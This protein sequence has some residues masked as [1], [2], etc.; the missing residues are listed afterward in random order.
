M[1]TRCET[2]LEQLAG[3]GT[4]WLEGPPG[5]GKSALASALLHA[6]S[7]RQIWLR[8]RGAHRDLERLEQDLQVAMP[9][10]S[11]GPTP[12]APRPYAD[13]PPGQCIAGMLERL[14]PC[15]LVLDGAEAVADSK[16]F[17]TWLAELATL[18]GVDNAILVT[19]RVPPP[20]SLARLRLEARMG[21]MA[22]RDLCLSATEAQALA[23][24]TVPE[25]ASEPE[26]VRQA[27]T[28]SKGWVAGFLA[29]LRRAAGED[30][31]LFD[32]YLEHEV[33][34]DLPPQVRDLLTSMA[35]LEHTPLAVARALADPAEQ[36]RLD[37]LARGNRLLE[38]NDGT[39]VLHP[40]L[41]DYLRRQARQGDAGQRYRRLGDALAA[42]GDPERAIGYWLAAYAR[43]PAAETIARLAPAMLERG[44]H[45][46]LADWI[47]QLPAAIRPPGSR[48]H[49][50][51]G[52]ALAPRDGTA[53]QRLLETAL[54]TLRDHGDTSGS[55]LAWAGLVDQA[56]L[57]WGTFDRLEWLL[58]ELDAL[59][60]D[61]MNELEPFAAVQLAAAA[62]LL[63]GV[64]A[65][66]DPRCEVWLATAEQ[67]A[68]LPV[69][70]HQRI[71]ALHGL[72][73]IDT[74]MYGHRGR[75]VRTLEQG[76]VAEARGK[77]PPLQEVMW[78]AAVAGYQ[79]WFEPDPETAGRRIADALQ[80][81]REHDVHLWDFQL[82][83][84]GACAALRRG[85]H[86]SA[87]EWLER[88]R[89]STQPSQ[90]TDAS[91]QAWVCG[92]I[93]LRAGDVVAAASLAEDAHRLIA[94]RGPANAQLLARLA[95][96]RSL[97]HGGQPRKS[98]HK[99]IAIDQRARELH[100]PL[101]RWLARLVASQ[102]LVDI[103]RTIWADE[104]LG[105]T[106]QDG[107]DRGYRWIPWSDRHE[108]DQLCQR[109]IDVGGDGD[110]VALLARGNGLPLWRPPEHAPPDT[111]PLRIRVLGPLR[112]TGVDG[113]IYLSGK[114]ATLL[115]LIAAAG[116]R[117]LPET[118]ALDAL[119]P[120]AEG[121]RARHAFDT[122]LHRVR[123][124]LG[125][126]EAI[127]LQNQRLALD[128]AVCW[129]DIGAL[130]THLEAANRDEPT[131]WEAAL[132][133]AEQSDV[134]AAE[135]PHPLGPHLRQH[136]HAAA[137]HA[138]RQALNEQR[139]KAAMEAARRAQAVDPA[140]EPFCR[141]LLE[142]ARDHG[143]HAVAT[144]AFN[145][146]GNALRLENNRA[147]NR[148]LVALY[149]IVRDTAEGANA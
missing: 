124:K 71:R 3:G 122:L 64:I 107:R 93:R 94:G 11:K 61:G 56:W 40:L 118:H 33:L 148:A 109:G 62:V 22:A 21:H 95:V 147:P 35:L 141:W 36:E 104:L 84:L 136:F 43:E 18:S 87:Q 111:W 127:R 14:G 32:Q 73:V 54:T 46:I 145:R 29:T 57:Q 86:T 49:L 16:A 116:S 17:G 8:L 102:A 129:T 135:W 77:L 74:W 130:G 37:E 101:Y 110:Y 123:R 58:E 30:P 143:N 6:R 63:L 13:V 66:D 103:G 146:Y 85:D 12:P 34:S 45:T 53:A 134:P 149:E 100:A 140:H 119:W 60:P 39:L 10:V 26:R 131:A 90:P 80:C 98:L 4:L 139:P 79:L 106:L 92:W 68:R 48:L 113:P 9:V 15:T 88:T 23:L 44:E 115:R 2:W 82:E 138:I 89:L 78:S 76:R 142:L 128:P 112:V 47:G 59:G 105:Q 67:V 7:G 83:A 41:S 27:L 42:S 70:D 108:L 5:A 51:Y 96:A 31:A 144:Q 50:W 38:W 81:A 25:I 132:R 120:D 75:A 69:P 126:A 72:L 125:I 121:D 19:A 65:P 97:R 55:A 114:S 24:T 20:C 52:L 133:I 137:D 28:V 117:E 99:A 1:Q 91:F